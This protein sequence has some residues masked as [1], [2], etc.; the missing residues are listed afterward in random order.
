MEQVRE[1][2]HELLRDRGYHEIESSNETIII[3]R[4]EHSR[5][6]LVYF[7]SCARVSVKKIKT[8]KD[9][10]EDDEYGFFC[11]MIICKGS[12]TSFAKQF[13]TT[14]VNNLYVQVF[15]EKELSFNITKHMLVPKHELMSSDEKAHIKTIYKTKLKHFPNLLSTDPVSK[16][17]GY[18]P[19]DL[20]RVTRKSP[21]AGMYTSYRVVV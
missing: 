2:V 18:L 14:D 1:V 4:N 5:R 15:S 6:M 12:I 19:G 3:A 13:I 7:V 20:V 16:Y 21:T 9:I 10:I 17:Y 11:L 8:I